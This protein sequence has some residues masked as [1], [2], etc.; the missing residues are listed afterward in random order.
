MPD[1]YFNCLDGFMPFVIPINQFS[2][3]PINERGG[4]L[5]LRYEY[6]FQCSG[7]EASLSECPVEAFTDVTGAC[8]TSAIGI[9]CPNDGEAQWCTFTW[10]YHVMGCLYAV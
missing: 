7:D 1:L 8:R 5:N 9:L 3:A 6:G 2:R 10:C 4:T